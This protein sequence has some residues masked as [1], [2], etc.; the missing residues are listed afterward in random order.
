[1]PQVKVWNDNVHPFQQKFRDETVKIGAKAFVW[2]DQ[3]DAVMFAGSFSPPVLGVDGEHRPEGFKMIRIERTKD[4]PPSTKP[5][6]TELDAQ[7]CMVCRYQAANE[8]DFE[9]HGKTHASQALKDEAAE[10]EIKTRRKGA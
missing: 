5:E 1:M 2:M 10:A 8:K 6:K 3:D 9:E 7:V 4:A